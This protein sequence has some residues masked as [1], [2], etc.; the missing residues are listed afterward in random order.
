VFR[1]AS[2]APEVD[3]VAVNATY[4]PEALAHVLRYDSAH[5]SFDSE[6]ECVENGL[7][8]AGK[9]VALTS[10]RDPAKLPWAEFNAEVII[11]STGSFR[12][13]EGAAKHFEGGAQKVIITA[14]AE[15]VD[16]TVVYGVNH[17]EYDPATHNIISTASCTTNC[18]APVVQILDEEFGIISGLI[19]TVHAYTS[20]QNLLDNPSEDLRRSRAAAENIIPTSTGAASAIGTVL[21]RLNGK[22]NGYAMR[23]PV[24]NGSL[25]D[26]VVNLEDEP[27]VEE[28]NGAFA[29]AAEG[30]LSG[31]LGYTESPVVSSDIVGNSHSSTVDGLSTMTIGNMAKVFAWYDNEWGTA[32]RVLDVARMA[33]ES[34]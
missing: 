28:L 3:V 6:V 32:N 9:H 30:R 33:A 7:E 15:N 8:I 12:S 13:R 31:V 1:A 5:G 4:S 29:E 16:I 19:T 10:S 22:L 23:V 17:D 26:L 25:L 34:L 11:E 24:S 27:S 20:S 14:P 21:P 2:N 18:L